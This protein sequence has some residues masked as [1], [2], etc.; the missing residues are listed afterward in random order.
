MAGKQLG[1][2]RQWAGEVI[3]SRERTVVTEEFKELEEDID[4]RKDGIRRVLLASGAYHHQLSKKKESEALDEPD[5]LLP[6]DALGIVMIT[7]GEALGESSTFGSAL[8]KLGR[9]HCKAATIQEAFALTL[10]D[11]FLTAWQR[12]EDEIKDYQTQRKKLESRRLSY[13][14]AISKFEKL[15]GGKKEKE[16]EK[17]EAEDEMEKARSRYEETLEDVRAIMVAIQENEMQQIRELT[18]FLDVERNYVEQY[19][20]LL[21][22]TKDNW[23]DVPSV[24]RTR[25]K[26]SSTPSRPTKEPKS[27]TNS[28]K[29]NKSAKSKPSRSEVD[30]E[31]RMDSDA[32]SDAPTPAPSQRSTFLRRKSDGGS[33]APSRAPSRSSRKRTDSGATQGSGTEK[34]VEKEKEKEKREKELE[35]TPSKRISVTGW[36]SSAVGSIMGK[37]DKDKFATLNGQDMDEE[38]EDGGD[39]GGG[40]VDKRTRSPSVTAKILKNRNAD[41]PPTS[42]SPKIT[43]RALSRTS[44]QEKK[45]VKALYDFSGSSDELSFKAGDKIVVVNEVLD[46]WWMGELGGKTGLFPTTYTE[47]VSSSPPRST[48]PIPPR[49]LGKGWLSSARISPP[50]MSDD[51][52][53]KQTLVEPDADEEYATASDHEQHVFGDHY[54]VGNS[55]SPMYGNFDAASVQSS[56]AEDQEE[57]RLMPVRGVTPVVKNILPPALGKRTPTDPLPITSTSGKKAPPPPPP[58][59]ATN[60]NSVPPSIAA[61]SVPSTPERRPA[62]LRSNS[63]ASSPLSALAHATRVNNGFEASPFDSPVDS[64][65]GPC[66]DFRQNPFK[67]LGMCSNCFERHG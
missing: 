63:S 4:L 64:S 66:R 5:K 65:F 13:D 6:I 48:P 41:T 44:T 31:G 30:E 10:Q 1:K 37:R 40:S 3:S 47:P 50:A 43:A 60:S 21:Q 56:E 22:D 28:V 67:P 11:T 34:D 58:R 26:E 61:Q 16:K 62:T 15:K 2:F 59:R 17:N 57:E 35:K 20:D 54:V 23:V 9:A 18:S 7:H 14:A 27:R 53:S 38:D 55:R 25:S 19:R 29:S 33:K 49:T 32:D 52:E 42:G 36:A 8:V 46:G 51:E 39:G 12:Y 45:M 24:T